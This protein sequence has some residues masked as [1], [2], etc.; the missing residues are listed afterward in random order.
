MTAMGGSAETGRL[1]EE[2]A[3][4]HLLANGFE[5]LERGWRSGRLEVDIIARRGDTVHVVEVKCRRNRA[6]GH[7]EFAP[8][9][10]MNATKLERL[11]RAVGDYMRAS[12]FEGEVSLDLIA[13][14]ITPTGY[15]V[16]YYPGVHW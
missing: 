7:D 14:N 8:E 15:D 2:A 12:G 4:R 5:I 1:G 3:V 11:M 6:E 10:A 16:R 9:F 13:V